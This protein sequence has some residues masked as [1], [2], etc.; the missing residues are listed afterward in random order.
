MMA[1]S[2]IRIATPEN[3]ARFH[4]YAPVVTADGFEWLGTVRPPFDERSLAGVDALIVSCEHHWPTRLAI[5]ACKRLGIPT[6]HVLDGIVEWRNLFENPR[7][8]QPENGPPLFQPLLSDHTFTMGEAQRRTLE[9]LGNRMVTATGLPRFDGMKVNPCRTGR[10]TNPAALLIATANTPWFT[11]E[12]Q[13]VFEREFSILIDRFKSGAASDGQSFHC[14][15]R[16][17]APVAER[18]GLVRDEPGSA[19]EALA[20]CDALI[21]T[22]SSLAVEAMLLGIP[23]LVFDPFACPALTPNAWSATSAGT[24]MELLPSL[25]SPGE[26]RA[27]LQD[28]LREW[29]TPCDAGASERVRAWIRSI[30]ATG[31]PPTDAGE[32]LQPPSRSNDGNSGSEAAITYLEGLAATIPTLDR[33]IAAKQ[34]EI[35]RLLAERRQPTLRHSLGCL[36]RCLTPLWKRK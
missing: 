2:P 19:A 7:S 20:L 23:T 18:F 11:D 3:E 33:S 30:V 4:H 35:E 12:Q 27:G 6:F 31:S 17:A 21:T 14:R 25:M 16:V 22:P 29:I 10:P 8:S 1:M 34:R 24:V 32:F 13:H 5:A 15:W 36:Y 26:K 28:S 9:W